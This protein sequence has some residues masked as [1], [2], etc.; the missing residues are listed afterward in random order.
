MMVAAGDAGERGAVY[1]R[2]TR[3]HVLE[4]NLYLCT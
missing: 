4:F 3:N 1:L 2:E